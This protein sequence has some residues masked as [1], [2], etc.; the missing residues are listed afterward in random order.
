MIKASLVHRSRGLLAGLL[1]CAVLASAPAFARDIENLATL[2][3]EIAVAEEVIVS[4]MRRSLR[5][6]L[7]LSNVS[8]DY[9]AR[10]GALITM[11]VSASWVSVERNDPDLHISAEIES[12][13]DI[14]E[15][16]QEI[17]DQLDIAVT[18]YAPEELEGLRMLRDEQRE[19]RDE[20]RE[21]YGEL[22]R[23]RRALLRAEADEREE[24]ETVIAGLEEQLRVIEEAEAVISPS[25]NN[26]R[27]LALLSLIS[28]R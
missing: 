11:D 16:V 26:P 14:P 3:R 12:L 13:S 5:D 20:R 1:S 19:L 8:S 24:I 23:E 7:R 27:S 4:A 28:N 22:R 9:L 21:I 18:P 6:S 17:I 2:Q 25:H 10:Q 15:M